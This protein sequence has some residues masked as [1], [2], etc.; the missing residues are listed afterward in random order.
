MKNQWYEGASIGTGKTVRGLALPGVGV[1]DDR[2]ALH[3][4]AATRTTEVDA[5]S[6]VMIERPREPRK[7]QITSRAWQSGF[8]MSRTWQRDLGGE[9]YSFT[10]VIMPNGERRYFADRFNGNVSGPEYGC[11]WTPCFE[12]T[13]SAP[14]RAACPTCDVHHDVIGTCTTCGHLIYSDCEDDVMHVDYAEVFTAK[15][16]DHTAAWAERPTTLPA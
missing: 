10:A 5:D 3:D 11:A 16:G 12:A 9:L 13:I 1:E 8:G 15:H 6:M 7:V 14:H 4:P 2:V